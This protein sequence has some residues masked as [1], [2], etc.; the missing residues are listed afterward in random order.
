LR[1]LED[2]L[3]KEFGDDNIEMDVE[4]VEER[5]FMEVSVVGG[6][7]LHSM[8]KGD[9]YVDTPEKKKKLFDGIRAAMK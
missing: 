2:D 5:G 9:G 1:A 8:K 3:K 4:V 6:P 7:V